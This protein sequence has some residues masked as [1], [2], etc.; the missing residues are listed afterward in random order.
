M[1]ISDGYGDSD[2]FFEAKIIERERLI[3]MQAAER[4]SDATLWDDVLNEARITVWEVVS[5][6]PD[7]PGPY[8]N[9][10]VGKRITEVVMRGVWTGMEG[11]RG[12]AIDP[13]RRKDRDSFDDPL[14]M[15]EAS[16][17]DLLASVEW[18][19]HEGQILDAIRSLPEHHQRYV[20]LR[21]WG[22]WT[23]GELAPVIGVKATNQSRMWNESIRP[24]LEQ[25]L[26]HLVEVG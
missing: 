8:I 7:A 25:A 4:I 6:R 15:V 10:A 14:F 20:V 26:G 16:S 9:A 12:K 11:H 3:R 24:V 5:K 17:P 13:I 2:L 21:F 19:Y 23:P 18:S 22:G 1:T